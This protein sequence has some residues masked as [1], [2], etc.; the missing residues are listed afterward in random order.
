MFFLG[1]GRNT[2]SHKTEPICPNTA[3]TRI[4]MYSWFKPLALHLTFG[5]QI[6][7]DRICTVPRMTLKGFQNA[8]MSLRK[9]MGEYSPFAYGC[10]F[11]CST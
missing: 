2:F 9:K 5:N 4:D 1:L 3:T 7:I 10:E 11:A 8:D 6:Q